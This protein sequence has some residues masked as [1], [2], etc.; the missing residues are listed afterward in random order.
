MAHHRALPSIKRFGLLSTSALLDHFQITGEKRM[1]IERTV[2]RESVTITHPIHGTAVIRDQKPIMTDRRLEQALGGTATA[3]EFHLL[4][5]SKVFFWVHSERLAGLRDAQAYRGAPQLI[6]TLDTQRLVE[7]YG[8]Q[9]K[10]CPMN[11][12][13]CR[14]FAH[15]R[16]PAIFQSIADYN[17]E[18][19]RQR[20]GSPAKAVVECTVESGVQDVE[21]FI[22]KTE[23]VGK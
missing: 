19:W 22:L 5:N 4:L 14:P 16:S 17:F 15:P 8:N 13:A 1:T 10:L 12:G 20:R 21:R 2:R 7:A 18:F 11:S 6:L 9:M 3:A 23:I